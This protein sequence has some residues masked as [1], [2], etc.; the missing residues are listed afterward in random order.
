MTNTFMRGL[1]RLFSSDFRLKNK[2]KKISRIKQA[3]KKILVSK[4][5]K[6]TIKP[7][8]KKLVAKKKTATKKKT[9]KKKQLSKKKVVKKKATKKKKK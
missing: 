6:L 8:I 9:T 7:I 3:E 1:K 2:A 4:T 5:K